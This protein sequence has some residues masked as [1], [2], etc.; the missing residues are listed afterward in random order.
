MHPTP[1]VSA[2]LL[3]YG[4]EMAVQAAAS[5]Q[6][7]SQAIAVAVQHIRAR[8]ALSLR[9]EAKVRDWLERELPQAVR[10]ASNVYATEEKT[11]DGVADAARQ[12]YRMTGPTK[13]TAVGKPPF[14]FPPLWL[15]RLID[16]QT[17]RQLSPDCIRRRK[18][19]VAS[20]ALAFLVAG[21]FPPW[22]QT[23]DLNTTHTQTD[24]GYAFLLSPPVPKE[25][26]Y[27]IG[28]RLDNARLQ[29]EMACVLAASVGA[30]FWFGGESRTHRKR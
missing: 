20:A 3:S 12:L 13:F 15:Y 26:S 29:L 8:Q 23:V 24:A 1:E 17:A 19:I 5:G 9:D 30:W 21:L 28:M 10:N 14:I 27:A 2:A 7:S 22:V 6:S 18:I 16:G 25:Y 4:L 11:D